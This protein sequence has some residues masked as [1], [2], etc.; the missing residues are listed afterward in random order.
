MTDTI[1][2]TLHGDWTNMFRP[3]G[4]AVMLGWLAA[5]FA[6]VIFYAWASIRQR[7]LPHDTSSEVS[8]K[9]EAELMA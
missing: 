7:M 8:G 5:T 2:V 1:A 6:L 3:D 9:G 4:K